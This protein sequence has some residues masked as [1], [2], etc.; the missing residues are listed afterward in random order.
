M[1]TSAKRDLGRLLLT[2]ATGDQT[3]PATLPGAAERAFQKLC[4][5]LAELVTMVGSQ[6]LFSRALYLT[7]TQFPF[8]AGVRAGTTPE[9]CLEGLRDSVQGVEPAQAREGL[10]ALFATLIELLTT[11]IGEDLTLRLVAEVWPEM[12]LDDLGSERREA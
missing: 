12:P 7:R 9:A 10:A 5:Q 8:L 4:R 1:E 2:A 3:D 11:F 6:A